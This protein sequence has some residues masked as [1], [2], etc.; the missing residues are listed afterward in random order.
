MSAGTILAQFNFPTDL[1][2]FETI[3]E[4]FDLGSGARRG[5]FLIP[6][7]P[8]QVGR[9]A[10][11]HDGSGEEDHKPSEHAPPAAPFNNNT[12]PGRQPAAT[13]PSRRSSDWPGAPD[14]LACILTASLTVSSKVLLRITL[15]PIWM[16]YQT[17]QT[18]NPCED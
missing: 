12:A 2:Q 11:E 8:S 13:V 1:S 7:S 6:R 5:K 3:S 9:R 16:T 15:C 10:R 17:T 4:G 18:M 14:R